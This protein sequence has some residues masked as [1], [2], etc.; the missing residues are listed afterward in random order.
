MDKDVSLPPI[1]ASTM[2][3]L[4]FFWLFFISCSLLAQTNEGN[5]FW[6]S[7]MEHRDKGNNTMV[8]MITAKNNTTGTISMPLLGWQQNFTVAAN[9]V[10]LI[11]LPGAAETWGSE[12]ITKNGIVV[13]SALPVSVFIHQFS[14]FRA[15]ATVVLPKTSLGSEYY[16]LTH[17]GFTNNEG[18]FPS[19]FIVVGMEDSTEVNI[20][21]ATATVLDVPVGGNIS[22]VLNKGETYQVQAKV[23]NADMS[24]SFVSANK[25][26]N[27][28]AGA[29]WSTMPYGCETRDNLLEQMYPLSA[30]GKNFVSA[31]SA[32]VNGDI[33]RVMAAEDQTNVTVTGITTQ[34]YVINAG[35][36]VEFESNQSLFINAD[37]PV[38]AAQY[39]KGSACNGYVYGDPSTI[40][41]NSIEQI[42]DTVT[43]YNSSLQNII[44]NYINIIGKTEDMPT[45]SF[46]GQLLSTV[47][48]ILP[49][50]GNPLFSYAQVTTS[51]GSHTIISDG[52]GIIATAYGYGEFESYGYSG[53]ASF[54]SINANPIVEG[55][56]L[57]DTLLFQSGV[58]ANR[59]TVLW[60]LG[61]GT[62]S[63]E[64][65]VKHKYAALGTYQVALYTLDECLGFRDTFLQDVKI[66]LR[67]ALQLPDSLQACEAASITLSAPLL[68]D[69]TYFW[70]GPGGFTSYQKDTTLLQ[71]H[72]AQEG[73]YTLVGSVFGCETFPS[74]VFLKL[75]PLPKPSLGNDTIVCWKEPGSI[76]LSP[77]IFDVYIWQNGSFTPFFTARDSGEYF[78][79]VIDEHGCRNADSILIREVCPTQLYF[80]N[81]FAPDTDKLNQKFSILGS[82]II[83]I[84][85]S[86]FD[87]WGGLLFV[88]DADNP[89]W[90]GTSRGKPLCP[91]VYIW[92]A[93]VKGYRADGSIFESLEKGDVLLVR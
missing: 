62:T 51:T 63:T 77:G 68:A 74:E 5:E 24:G 28:L 23:G 88:S 37:K 6:F 20:T 90:D 54:R 44:E 55:G 66:T 26:V 87:R 1:D 21:V 76:I 3:I 89:A 59:F 46:D 18:H 13:T 12:N 17:K 25:K 15:E 70:E 19:E 56:C 40:L 10:T 81:V 92:M 14:Q 29:R 83:S 45:V 93:Q 38:L 11:N 75:H 58:K 27:V 72:A 4:G 80:P 41:L 50:Q 91:G 64:I 79:T 82:D 9:Q 67:Q 16:V 61:D 53:G 85:L 57:G 73:I 48:T 36:F 7:F 69:A 33:Y 49:V 71:L 60:D 22:V 65:E 86:I 52:C 78:V 47:A 32:K 8:A 31:P 2:R 84:Q 43:L 30:W 42:I 35:K 39:L 34:N